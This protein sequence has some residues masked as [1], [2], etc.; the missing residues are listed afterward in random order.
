[1][2]KSGK[3][4][5]VAR[6]LWHRKVFVS[7]TSRD[8]SDVRPEVAKELKTHGFE[9]LMFDWGTMKPCPGISPPLQ[10]V[11]NV[12]ESDLFILLL[13]AR[14]GYEFNDGR[15]A[16][17]AEYDIAV[18]L[19]T[20]RFVYARDYVWDF[21]QAARYSQQDTRRNGPLQQGKAEKIIQFYQKVADSNGSKKAD[22]LTSFKNSVDLKSVLIQQLQDFLIQQGQTPLT[23]STLKATMGV[24]GIKD[25]RANIKSC[26]K[27]L[28][29]LGYQCLG[30][31]IHDL[32]TTGKQKL[33][34]AW[35]MV[36][37]L[38]SKADEKPQVGCITVRVDKRIITPQ[39]LKGWHKIV[40][41]EPSAGKD[42]TDAYNLFSGLPNNVW[43]AVHRFLKLSAEKWDVI[44]QI[45][46]KQYEDELKGLTTCLWHEYVHEEI[47]Q[48]E[49]AGSDRK[50]RFWATDTAFDDLNPSIWTTENFH[51]TLL[52]HT[53]KLAHRKN[54]SLSVVRLCLTNSIDK[55]LE[56][57]IF[58]KVW[59]FFN[60]HV[61]GG[62]T[63]GIVPLQ[64][65]AP[66][67]VSYFKDFYL[68]PKRVLYRIMRK[69]SLHVVTTHEDME[70][71][72]TL[73]A[74]EQFFEHLLSL[75]T[76]VKPQTLPH[77]RQLLAEQTTNPSKKIKDVRPYNI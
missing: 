4:A 42:T 60:I 16:T 55:L 56:P 28:H 10:C 18:K 29:K 36:I 75:A 6:L 48:L 43:H 35:D 70:S 68:I 63:C 25:S 38:D 23:Y 62:V 47:S 33:Q 24:I 9:P 65:I 19:Q 72:K 8:F 50:L 1:M 17:E 26:L 51:L 2:S 74:Y 57:G 59:D 44:D 13:G 7:S 40:S 76:I 73:K 58:E 20:P 49:Q 61:Q 45:G 71:K 66:E 15:S 53:L 3:Y 41:S 12:E 14:W 46:K 54:L 37:S 30:R 11:R 22:F 39:D 64:Q 32:Q 77:L 34:Q 69:S 31:L 67:F 52:D 21:V 27:N 5:R